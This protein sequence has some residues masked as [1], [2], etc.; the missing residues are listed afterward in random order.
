MLISLTSPSSTSN[1]NATNISPSIV[2]GKAAS[3]SKL[4]T[5]PQLQN[6]NVVVVPQSYALSTAFFQ[7][8]VDEIIS[9]I[10]N[11]NNDDDDE[12]APLMK[13]IDGKNTTA[14]IDN[15]DDDDDQLLKETCQKLKSKCMTLPLT[16]SQQQTLHT[17]QNIISTSF[18]YKLA[19]VRSSSVEEDGT[20]D[21]GASEVRD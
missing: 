19:A 11:N 10:T 2:G 15:S 8:W 14:T 18:N 7:P 12:F 5:I 4:Y 1:T 21:E 13:I 6:Q 17:L 16:Q 3:L 20:A 9:W